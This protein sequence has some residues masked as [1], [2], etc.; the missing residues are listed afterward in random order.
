MILN[1]RTFL[2]ALAATAAY[3]PADAAATPNLG[4]LAE[5]HGLLFGSAFDREIFTDASYRALIKSS[6]RIG[7]VENSF[8]IDWLRRN[9]ITAD[10]RITDRLV[11]FANSA[12]IALRGTALVW[13]DWP[14]TWLKSLSAREVAAALD[15][16]V[17]ETIGRYAGRMQGWGVVNEPFYP[18]HRQTGGYRKGPWLEAMGPSYIPRAFKVAAAADPQAKL[19]LNEAFCEQ[20]DELGRSVRPRLLKLVA[21]LKHS[22]VKL[23]A[24]G[25]QAHLKPH[26]PYNDQAFATF[27]GQIAALDVDIYITEFDV[28]DEGM[29]D[30]IAKRDRLV[31]DRC[32]KFLRTILTI[33]RVKV[34]ICWHL[35]DRYSWYK[36][37]DWYARAIS[38]NGGDPTRKVRTHLTDGELRPK[39]AWDAVARAIEARSEH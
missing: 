24:V 27:L 32:E 4:S 25:F 16:H 36:D 37:A 22:G 30:D 13:N 39:L 21:E 34:L 9:G 23:D 20:D 17:G 28:D 11:Q 29:P 15:R 33:P 7:S 1:R 14:P 19:V 12:K 38:E 5:Q 2:A 18:P 10:F 8:K 26:L 31:A 3:R 6:C 35:S